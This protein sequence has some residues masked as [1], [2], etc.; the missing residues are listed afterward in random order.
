M[1]LGYVGRC[2]LEAE[3]ENT[4]IYSYTGENWNIPEE[5]ASELEGI[6]GS[7]VISKRSLEEPEIHVKKQR[8]G[9]GKNRV[10]EKVITHT[11]DISK[12]LSDGDITIESLCGVDRMESD[13]TGTDLP[14]VVRHLLHHVYEHYMKEGALPA[15][16]AFIQ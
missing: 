2:R 9:K 15:K 16:D 14:R 12:H 13:E 5:L 7:F 8:V 3:D 4:A 11:P 10:V 1:S 6:E